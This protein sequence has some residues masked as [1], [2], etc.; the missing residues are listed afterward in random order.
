VVINS[1]GL[2]YYGEEKELVFSTPDK[3]PLH[4]ICVEES[5]ARKRKDKAYIMGG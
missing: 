4:A 3:S 1:L 2:D 5:A